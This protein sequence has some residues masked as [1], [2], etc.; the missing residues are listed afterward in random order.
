MSFKLRDRIKN[1]TSEKVVFTLTLNSSPIDLT[2]ATMR[3][4]FRKAHKVGVLVKT[5]SIGS[6]LTVATP[7][8]G[9]FELDS[10][11][12]DFDACLYW[13]DIETTFPDGTVKTYIQGTM[14][15]LQD[16]TN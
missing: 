4:Q 13:Y 6:G 2:G 16:V 8:S 11:I 5:V 10:F 15:V 14:T 12:C 1:D 7:S 3:C 9:I